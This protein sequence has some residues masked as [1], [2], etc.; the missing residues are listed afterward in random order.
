MKKKVLIIAYNF[1]PL[2]GGGVQRTLKFSR[3]L[4]LFSWEPTVLT[5][6]NP[7]APLWDYSLVK[8]LPTDLQ[9][10]KAPAFELS[11]WE[12]RFF[13]LFK[14][15]S[16]SGTEKKEKGSHIPLEVEPSPSNLRA[17]LKKIYGFL[18]FWLRVP[19]D[20]VGWVPAAILE[21]LSLLR[22]KKIDLIYTTSPPHSSQLIGLFL[23]KL[24]GKPWV[25]DF[26]DD[27]LEDE[28]RISH[29][30]G[31][32]LKMEKKLG[33]R[34]IN[35]TSCM[36]ANTEFKKEVYDRNYPQAKR[37]E[38]IQNGFD[39]EDLMKA[40][41]NQDKW[42][43]GK[44]HL[45][46]TGYFYPGIALPFFETL[47]EF[48]LEHP[49][50]RGKI[51]IDLVGY[52][53]KEYQD[54]ITKNQLGDVIKLWGYVEH[55]SS[56]NFLLKSHLLLHLI[57][58]DGEFWK[59]VVAGKLYEYLASGKPILSFA[60]GGGES[61]KMIQQAKSGWVLD[62]NNRTGIKRKLKELYELFLKGE[63]K[64]EQN[65]SYVEGFERKNL[66]RKLSL[67]FDDCLANK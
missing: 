45:C 30:P 29:Y 27:W 39:A 1:P 5:V 65:K 64:V 12:N 38:V 63:L 49:E 36:I 22:S 44:F 52:L 8:E 13:S 3:Y 17:N 55:L 7:Y 41:Q 37:I 21:G 15:G 33:E 67:V 6:S 26:R 34:L 23:S 48:L 51:Q 20:Q 40:G 47:K 19:D 28:Q 50:L 54:A 46:H 18:T 35:S 16:K 14:A 59:G 66:T 31:F 60:P 58:S 25:A 11:R 56:I 57:G 62:L 42:Q 10:F 24:S 43:D 32:Y 9:V 53:E 4:P 61:E 2:G